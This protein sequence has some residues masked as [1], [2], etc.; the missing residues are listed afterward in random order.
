MCPPSKG[1]AMSTCLVGIGANLGN[2]ADTIRTA[3]GQLA[4]HVAIES[5]ALSGNFETTPV[6]GS[7]PQPD[8]LNAAV[9]LETSLDPST[10]LDLLHQIE[11]RCGRQRGEHW[12]ARTLD[13]DLL[14]Y[15]QRVIA[16]DRLTVPHPRMVFRRFVLQPAAEVAADLV[17][18]RMGWSV[19]QLL[20][21]LDASAYY[22]AIGGGDPRLRQRLAETVAAELDA[23]LLHDPERSSLAAAAGPIA[24]PTLESLQAQAH[25]LAQ[26][27]WPGNTQLAISDFWFDSWSLGAQAS[28]LGQTSG[29]GQ[30]VGEA[31]QTLRS[32]VVTPR[33]TLLL[34]D[35][36]GSDNETIRQYAAQPTL[37][38]V[39][40]VPTNDWPWAIA[41]TIA[42]CQAMQ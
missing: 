7:V 9:R 6:G 37:G 25:T 24:T 16:S 35:N 39:L 12:S 29:G 1:I 42:A 14:L 20:D 17:H 33:L 8:F 41:E 21:H 38:P 2:R 10:L 4:D 23:R 34:D 3:A 31:W 13:L 15:D 27:R 40:L 30:A 32:D 36:R 22:L 28:G 26:A 18:A 19:R 11:Q 5:I